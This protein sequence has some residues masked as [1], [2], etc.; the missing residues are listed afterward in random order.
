MKV[1]ETDRPGIFRVYTLKFHTS[2]PL[3]GVLDGFLTNYATD[4]PEAKHALI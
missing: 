3:P 4:T 1:M 2:Q